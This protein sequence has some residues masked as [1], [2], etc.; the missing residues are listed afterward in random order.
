MVGANLGYDIDYLWAAGIKFPEIKRYRDV[1][2]CEALIDDLAMSYSLETISQKYLGVGKDEGLLNAAAN[3]FSVDPKKE[4]YLLPARFVGEYAEQDCDLPLKILRRQEKEVEEQ[5][6]WNIWNTESDLL[7]VLIRMRQRGVRVNLKKL[8]HIEEWS[9][10]QEVEA[11]AEIKRLSG[12]TLVFGD[13]WK[14][15]ALAVPLR[16]VGF[17]IPLTPK[18]RKPSIDKAFLNSIDHPVA[19]AIKRARK[20]NKIRTTFANSIRE[21]AIGDRIHCIY[22]QTRT[23]TEEDED[24]EGVGARYGRCS[25]TNPNM[26]QQPARDPEIG[27]LWRSIYIPEEGELW[28]SAD[29]SAQEPRQAVHYA[30]SAKLGSVKVRTPNG[31]KWVDADASARQ[32]LDN[33]INDPSTDPHQ[34]LADIIYGRRATKDER[35]GAKIIFLGLSYGM[36]GP[37]LCRSLGYPTINVAR[38]PE[39][40]EILDITTVDGAEAVRRGGKIF[41]AAGAE[42]QALLDKFDEAVP[43]VRALARVCQ[44]AANRYGYI[45]TQA[46]R[47][48]RFR[49]D[50]VGNILESHKSLNKLI[51]GSSAD[52]TKI[53][54][55]ALDKEGIFLTVQVHDE[56]CASIKN[57]KEGEMIVEIMKTAYKLKVPNKIDLEIGIDWGSA[58]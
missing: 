31:F 53:S 23:S 32:M 15:E 14:A 29:F 19:E 21:H 34:A 13:V 50:E 57:K 54:L 43:F 25:A 56:A 28:A 44:K 5:E 51:Q 17:T 1:Q 55:I 47:K 16:A 30:A 11:L 37:K 2:I 36:G 46:G 33:Y 6:L 42:G 20:V 45:R 38:H 12:K 8:E 40:G 49:R 4:M 41:E 27:P 48:C 10:K 24:G 52:Q 39:T 18:T 9:R 26:Q 3:A 35:A 7:P 22:H 58:K